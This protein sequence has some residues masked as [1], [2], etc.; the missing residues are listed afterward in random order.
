VAHV[1]P[2]DAAVIAIFYLGVPRTAAHP[3][4]AKLFINMLMSEAGQRTVYE[5]EYMDHVG[6][7]GSQSVAELNDVRAKGITPLKVDARFIAEHPEMERLSQE[8]TALLRD[9][10]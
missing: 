5:T 2:E 6:L 10:R 8:L 1:I 7:P 9:R 3:N 4:L